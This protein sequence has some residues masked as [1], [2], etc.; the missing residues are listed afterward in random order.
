MADARG[1]LAGVSTGAQIP[2]PGPIRRTGRPLTGRC[3]ALRTAGLTG[4]AGVG[5]RGDHTYRTAPTRTPSP[6]PTTSSA[7]SVF[8]NYFVKALLFRPS[9]RHLSPGELRVPSSTTQL[10]TVHPHTRPRHPHAPLLPPPPGETHSSP[11]LAA[12]FA[13]VASMRLCRTA[14]R[15]AR[16]LSADIASASPALS[17]SRASLPRLRGEAS[18]L[19]ACRPW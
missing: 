8:R 3:R 13:P 6:P 9:R 14:S 5:R 11:S 18:T 16:P 7:D 15:L 19:Y 1:Q 17:V 2:M 4:A 12:A 10:S